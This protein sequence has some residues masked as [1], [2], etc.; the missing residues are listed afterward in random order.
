[1]LRPNK[2]MLN[3]VGLYFLVKKLISIALSRT[4]IC[5]FF[6]SSE[7]NAAFLL[8]THDFFNVYM[9]IRAKLMEKTLIEKNIFLFSLR[10]N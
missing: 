10:E 9:Y 2:T 4:E 6:Q 7:Y 5:A 8:Y 3:D 1:V